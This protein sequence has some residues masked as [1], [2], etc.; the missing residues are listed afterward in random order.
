[1]KQTT[2][3]LPWCP[4][5]MGGSGRNVLESAGEK[6]TLVIGSTADLDTSN[7]SLIMYEILSLKRWLDIRIKVDIWKVIITRNLKLAIKLI[8][9][10]SWRRNWIINNLLESELIIALDIFQSYRGN[11]LVKLLWVGDHEADTSLHV[12]TLTGMGGV[13]SYSKSKCRI[14]Y[15]RSSRS[16]TI[17]W[18]PKWRILWISKSEFSKSD[19]GHIEVE[20]F[21]IVSNIVFIIFFLQFL[22]GSD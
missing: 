11:Q 21:Q 19:T 13:D 15:I 4:A 5:G 8:L 10:F 16:S 20:G 6:D 2:L 3:W 1:M 18:Y 17:H 9:I 7:K 12:L 22:L 14:L